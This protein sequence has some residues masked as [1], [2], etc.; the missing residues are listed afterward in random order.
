MERYEDEDEPAKPIPDIEETVDSNGHALNQL[1]VYDRLLNAEVQLQHDNRV[2]TGKV[3]CRALGPD[4][5]VVG[6]YDNNLMLNS[7]MYE[8]KFADRTVKEYGAN[9]ITENML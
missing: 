3:K 6:K 9:I 8:V 7:I 4:G 2:T 5:N 1:P